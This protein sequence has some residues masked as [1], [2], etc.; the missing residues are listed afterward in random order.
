MA[1][2]SSKG[3]TCKIDSS[4]VLMKHTH[5]SVRVSVLWKEFSYFYLHDL[6]QNILKYFRS[7]LINS[8]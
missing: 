4:E 1:I 3:N 8:F 5:I 2:L 7:N 6:E